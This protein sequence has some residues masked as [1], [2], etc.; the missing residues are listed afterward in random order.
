MPCLPAFPGSYISCARCGDAVST[1][2]DAEQCF[3]AVLG[4]DGQAVG[5]PMEKMQ[6]DSFLGCRY[7]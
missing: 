5:M 7:S 2:R 6:V 1:P 3:Q 4:E